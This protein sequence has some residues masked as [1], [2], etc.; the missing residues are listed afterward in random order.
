MVDEDDK[1]P[2]EVCVWNCMKNSPNTLK[3]E[4]FRCFLPLR[5]KSENLLTPICDV[6]REVNHQHDTVVWQMLQQL[7]QRLNFLKPLRIYS[8]SDNGIL[9]NELE[10]DD[11]SFYENT[12]KRILVLYL[13]SLM[14]TELQVDVVSTADNVA[15]ILSLN[16]TEECI[17]YAH[18]IND[19]WRNFH[20][21][22]K[23]KSLLRLCILQIRNSMSSM[24]DNSFLSLPVTPFTRRLLTYRDVTERIYEEWCKAITRF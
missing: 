1:L 14:L 2:I 16:E 20:Q 3:A 24:D 23:V 5:A 13:V 22:C 8:S 11:F 19:L 12:S 6:L 18:A 7:I 17:T 15:Q 10:I 21:R 9:I 4:H